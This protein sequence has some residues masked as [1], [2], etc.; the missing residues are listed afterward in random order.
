MEIIVPRQGAGIKGNT[1]NEAKCGVLEPEALEKCCLS[2][3]KH[4]EYIMYAVIVP[5]TEQGPLPHSNKWFGVPK[6]SIIG[7]C[8]AHSGST[9]GVLGEY[10]RLSRCPD[11]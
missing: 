2:M 8:L 7:K 1:L 3:E 10:L 4:K 6:R 5:I 11:L 9:W